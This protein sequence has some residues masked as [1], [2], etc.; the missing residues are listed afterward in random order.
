MSRKYECVRNPSRDLYVKRNIKDAAFI[1]LMAEMKSGGREA[2]TIPQLKENIKVLSDSY[3][4]ELSRKSGVG[5]DGVYKPKLVWFTVAD[6]FWRNGFSGRE[7][8]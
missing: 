2:T 1:E 3:R 4:L 8:T 5:L 6:L 7:S